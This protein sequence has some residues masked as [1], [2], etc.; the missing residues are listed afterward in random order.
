MARGPRFWALG[1]DSGPREETFEVILDP[2][3]DH[4]KYKFLL[5]PNRT[6][7]WRE[8]AAA[9]GL[10]TG[11]NLEHTLLGAGTTVIRPHTGVALMG[12]A[13]NPMN[14]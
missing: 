11:H 6:A 3:K 12:P 10:A 8:L 5:V 2:P 14:L 1:V 13:P 4:G 7:P 9:K